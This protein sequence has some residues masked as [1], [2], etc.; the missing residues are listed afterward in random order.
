MPKLIAFLRAINVG[1]HTVKMDHLR[2]LFESIGLSE[3]E[4]FIA[5]GNVMFESEESDLARLEHAIEQHLHAALGFEVATF[6]RTEAEL[7]AISAFQPFPP[8]DLEQAGAF[9]LAFLHDALD[10]ATTQK[11]MALKTYIDDFRVH[12][13]E[14]YW[15]CRKKQSES[16]FSNAVLEKTIGRPVTLRGMN[17]IRKIVE[18]WC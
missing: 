10:E 17:T 2:R 3:V 1:G 15:L 14:V 6:I 13:R 9:N 18:R 5:S 11:L 12:G 8:A 7:R 16:T 4:T